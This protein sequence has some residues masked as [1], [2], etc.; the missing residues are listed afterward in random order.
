[1]S[2]CFST[3]FPRALNFEP[4]CRE[5]VQRCLNTSFVR[6]LENITFC[7][8]FANPFHDFNHHSNQH[9]PPLPLLIGDMRSSTKQ[10]LAVSVYACNDVCVSLSDNFKCFHTAD[11]FAALVLASIWSRNVIV[12][13]KL[14]GLF[15]YSSEQYRFPDIRC[16]PSVHC[17][18]VTVWK[19]LITIIV[20]KIITVIYIIT[21]LFK[22]AGDVQKVLTH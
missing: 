5:L 15:A 17:R 2:K 12:R 9:Q 11:V 13:Y 1:M 3:E 7:S 21:V 10:S 4:W 19:F 22:F 6:V 8:L 16:I 18:D 20:T 14:F